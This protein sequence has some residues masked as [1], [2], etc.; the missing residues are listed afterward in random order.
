METD[1]VPTDELASNAMS[2][3]RAIY[4]AV[5]AASREALVLPAKS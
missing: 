2:H 5:L 4:D 3:A 1:I